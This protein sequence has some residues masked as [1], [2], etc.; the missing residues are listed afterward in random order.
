MRV[1]ADF[2]W[3]IIEYVGTNRS[4]FTDLVFEEEDL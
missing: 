4:S 3:S 1:T 2:I